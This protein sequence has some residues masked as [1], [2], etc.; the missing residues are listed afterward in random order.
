MSKPQHIIVIDADWLDILAKDAR[1]HF[2]SRIGRN[3]P[4]VELCSLV[5]GMLFHCSPESE[6]KG[7]A[8]HVVLVHSEGLKR[9]QDVEVRM[10][11][12]RTLATLADINGIRFAD[13]M[14]DT[15]I[16]I[17][18]TKGMVS[19]TDALVDATLTLAQEKEV[20]TIG[21]L[22]YEEERNNVLSR[23][24]SLPDG[25][26]HSLFCLNAGTADANIIFFLLMALGV[27]EKELQM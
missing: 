8:N 15:T 3:L 10:D 26:S 23:L 9:F 25:K 6:G 1:S 19:N 4:P 21:V 11:G 27:S 5:S 12:N 17:C 20:T 18:P 13:T 14:G 7:C 24:S 2:S 22:P 16:E